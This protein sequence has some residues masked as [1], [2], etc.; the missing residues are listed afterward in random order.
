MSIRNF[1]AAIRA[2][3][4]AAD[5]SS[6][7][8]S[9]AATAAGAATAATQAKNDSLTASQAAATSATNASASASTAATSATS[10]SA[11]AGNASASATAA[12]GSATS[13]ANSAATATTQATN[14]SSSATNAATSG[15]NA[16]ASATTATTQATS[17]ATSATNAATSA[18]TATTQATNAAT[19]ATNAATSA[20][21]ALQAATQSQGFANTL[22]TNPTVLP[23]EVT[24]ISGG[25]GTGTGGTDGTYNLGV[26]GGPA[27]FQATVMISGGKIASYAIINPGISASNT[28]PTLSLSGVTGL[29]GATTPTATVGTIPVNRVF[30]APDAT[31]TYELAWINNAGSLSQF[32]TTGTQ[33][34]KY[35]KA[36]IDALFSNLNSTETIGRSVNPISGFSTTTGTYAFANAIALNGTITAIRVYGFGSG[37]IKVR[38]FTLSGTTMT[39]VGSDTNVAISVGLNTY[40]V[41]IAVNA[42]EYIGF[43][44]PASCIGYTSTTGDSGGYYFSSSD[45]TSYN[46]TSGPRTAARLEIGFDLTEPY[47]TKTRIQGIESNVTT[48]QAGA[49]SANAGLGDLGNASS[50]TVEDHAATTQFASTA[51]GGWSGAV[52]LSSAAVGTVIKRIGFDNFY[53]DATATKVNLK[54]YLRPDAET[55]A[56]PTNCTLVFSQDYALAALGLTAG[57]TNRQTILCQFPSNF[58]KTAGYHLAFELQAQNGSSAKVA[59][60]IGY[61]SDTTSTASERGWYY[62]TTSTSTYTAIASPNRIAVRVARDGYVPFNKTDLLAS[63]SSTVT[64]SGN[65][66]TVSGTL[67]KNGVDYPYSGTTTLT[68]AASGTERMDKLVLAR[69]TLALSAVAGSQRTAQ[70]DSLEWQ[71][72]TP[73]D[74]IVVARARV[75]NTNVQA[76]SC[77]NFRGLIKVG[78]EG[79]MAMQID[80]NRRILRGLIGKATRGG[81][82]KLGGYGDSITAIQSST[83]PYTANGTMRDRGLTFLANYPADTQALLTLY[84]TGDGAGAVHTRLGWNWIIKSAL[85]KLGGTVTYNNYGIGGTTSQNTTD[86]GLYASRIAVPLADALDV[87]VIA[88]GMNERGQSYTYANI[89]NMI[90]Q[91]QAVGTACIVMGCTRPNANQSVSA[92]RYTNDALET[93]AMDAGAAYVSTVAISDDRNLGGIGV[94]AEALASANTISGGNNHPG[95]YE[96]TQYGNS[97][98]IQLGLV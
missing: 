90:G 74:S 54:I 32:P 12:S 17:A 31:G 26:T 60:S 63:A 46:D 55:N 9:S 84:D 69:S 20:A 95:I 24:A 66:V 89:V 30:T 3:K 62:G 37:T 29:T 58:T 16:A 94:P 19:S 42:G 43:Y 51:F 71:G 39:Q 28:A 4:V 59:S 47:V 73:A 22:N 87:V 91:F 14:A 75:G 96:L 68:L 34:Q 56:P 64:V 18:T 70:L 53:V 93:A 98:V 10:A 8:A 25:V 15:T 85:E 97:A 57:S 35:Y 33:F 21:Q 52:L 81:T 38:R 40:S 13:A 49:T 92:W 2:Q 1:A 72:A 6:A 65:Q 27:G 11:S 76:A 83:P 80:R 79:E 23:F 45:S 36:S 77:A 67:R 82:I 7:A 50:I 86:N 61:L 48:A 44:T 88:F 78:T 41:N 5:A